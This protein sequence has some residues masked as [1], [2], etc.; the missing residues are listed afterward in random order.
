MEQ[1]FFRN[2]KKSLFEL[3]WQ[4]FGSFFVHIIPHINLKIE[5]RGLVKDEKKNGISL[6]FGETSTKNLSLEKN[7]IKV[8]LQFD[9]KWEKLSIPWD[10][11]LAFYDKKQTSITQLATFTENLEPEEKTNKS[12]KII[13]VNFE[14]ENKTN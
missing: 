11:V 13:Q 5:N 7:F 10:A 14:K 12:N 8:E 9:S 6:I 1:I 3:Y 4:T 2:Y